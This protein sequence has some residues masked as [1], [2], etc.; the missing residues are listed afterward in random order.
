[1]DES[2]IS[3]SQLQEFREIVRTLYPPSA[4]TAKP[5]PETLA[6]PLYPRYKFLAPLFYQAVLRIR[7]ANGQ[8]T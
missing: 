1:M 2:L 8:R 3:K 4:T 6:H 7:R 5:T